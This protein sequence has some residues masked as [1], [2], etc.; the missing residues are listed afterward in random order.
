[1]TLLRHFTQ[2]LFWLALFMLACIATFAIGLT[3]KFPEILNTV[4]L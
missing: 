4:H 2:F 1:M 3:M